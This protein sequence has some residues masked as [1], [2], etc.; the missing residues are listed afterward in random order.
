MGP[1]YHGPER[2]HGENAVDRTNYKGI[3][4]TAGV[5]L[6]CSLLAS[7]L[8]GAWGASHQLA[9]LTEQV[10]TLQSADLRMEAEMQ[11]LS[12]TKLDVRAHDELAANL[13]DY[14]ARNEASH[15]EIIKLLQQ[16]Q[17]HK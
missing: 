7:F 17:G 14:M 9:A 16:M 1:N 5:A 4:L 3:L 2:R 10:K 15:M 8:G 6:L 13:R 11:T 12:A